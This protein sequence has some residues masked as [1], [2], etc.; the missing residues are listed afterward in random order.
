M[1]AS[2]YNLLIVKLGLL[3][4]SFRSGDWNSCLIVVIKIYF[5]HYPDS[6]YFGL[7]FP[8]ST[9]PPWCLLCLLVCFGTPFAFVFRLSAVEEHLDLYWC[10][11][12]AV[13]QLIVVNEGISDGWITKATNQGCPEYWYSPPQRVARFP[14]SLPLEWCTLFVAEQS[15]QVSSRNSSHWT[16]PILNFFSDWS[17]F[18]WTRDHQGPSILR[19]Y[20]WCRNCLQEEEWKV[21]QSSFLLN[22]TMGNF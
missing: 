14:S 6:S 12:L 7:G 2:Y 17:H 18:P 8:H 20:F 5:Q 13:I 21:R 11:V 9:F 15:K 19:W 10:E 4:S 3:T 22:L 1:S 16:A